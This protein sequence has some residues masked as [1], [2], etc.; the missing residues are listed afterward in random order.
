MRP[1]NARNLRHQP[2]RQLTNYGLIPTT[3]AGAPRVGGDEDQAGPQRRD[4][5]ADGQLQAVDVAARFE[6]GL[7]VGDADADE[8]GG[9]IDDNRDGDAALDLRASRGAAQRTLAFVSGPRGLP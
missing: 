4:D 2:Y 1:L 8:S 6:R 5:I 7:R 3:T 9:R